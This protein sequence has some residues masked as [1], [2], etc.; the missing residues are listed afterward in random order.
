[1]KTN[2][3]SEAAHELG[4]TTEN[5]VVSKAAM[6]EKINEWINHDFQKLVSVLYR[7]DV[8]EERLRKVLA[9]DPGTDAALIITNLIIE[10][11][12]QKIKSRRDSTQR[13]N[14]IDENEKW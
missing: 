10:R 11:Q 12:E 7:M 14:N 1:M 2:A 3:L 13:E 5:G 4:I 9:D 8:N 6:V